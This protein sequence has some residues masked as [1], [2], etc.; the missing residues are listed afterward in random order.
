MNLLISVYELNNM[1]IP[2]KAL[3]ENLSSFLECFLNV[4]LRSNE[5]TIVGQ[6]MEHNYCVLE[7][8]KEVVHEL[9]NTIL[10][11]KCFDE[12]YT[13]FLDTTGIDL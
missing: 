2:N 9:S 3:N 13:S 6:I 7:I 11:L 8:G 10:S 5:F 12:A 4:E 1:T